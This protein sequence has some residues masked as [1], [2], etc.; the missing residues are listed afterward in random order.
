M[1]WFQRTGSWGGRSAP[2]HAKRVF[3]RRLPVH[4]KIRMLLELKVLVPV[5]VHGKIKRC[6]QVL[7]VEY[8]TFCLTLSPM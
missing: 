7:V 2:V 8:T 1:G 4:Q 3:K 6:V 5:H